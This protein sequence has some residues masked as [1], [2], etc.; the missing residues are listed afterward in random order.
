VAGGAA[1]DGTAEQLG[2]TLRETAIRRWR[3]REPKVAQARE[4]THRFGMAVP[5]LAIVVAVMGIL[6]GRVP[7]MAGIAGVLAA[8]ALAVVFGLLSL[9]PELRAIVTAAN[10]LR[11]ARAFRR[12]DDEAAVIECAIARAWCETVP[13][14]LRWLQ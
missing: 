10:L 13:P 1:A 12:E 8:T 7:P 11:A 2:K 4:N 6:V 14:V 9:G 5:P 3:E